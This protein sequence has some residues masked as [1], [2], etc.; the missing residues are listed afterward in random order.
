MEKSLHQKTLA[1]AIYSNSFES[2]NFSSRRK[3]RLLVKVP[4]GTE[5]STVIRRKC[6]D[7]ATGQ[8]SFKL[9]KKIKKGIKKVADIHKKVLKK[10]VQV[11]KKIA[12][13]SLKL[14]KKGIKAIGTATKM[15]V[16]L[17]LL[18]VI[19]T[20]LKKKK[21][22]VG[23]NPK[24]LVETFYNVF[25][26]KKKVNFDAFEGDSNS[27]AFAAIIPVVLKFVTALIKKKKKGGSTGDPALDAAA[28][29]GEGV[30]EQIE[31]KAAEEG[32]NLQDIEAPATPALKSNIRSGSSKQDVGEDSDGGSSG[33]ILDGETFGISNKIIAAIIAGIVL[34]IVVRK[35]F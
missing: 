3:R 13:G 10:T 12:K 5:L 23:N 31:T 7:P 29:Q 22:N 9:F 1:N 26:A 17:P 27:V 8:N 4:A 34:L 19:K 6:Y 33:G 18:P 28:D 32:V 25:I 20:A 2:N 30:I 21:V 16:L 35:F 15:A 14:A 24:K 11:H